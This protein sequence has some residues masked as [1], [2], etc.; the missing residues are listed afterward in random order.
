M[1]DLYQEVTNRIIEQLEAGIIPWNKPWT[2]SNAGA[3]SHNTGRAYSL[4]N[5]ILLMKPGEYLTFNQCKAEGGHIKKG[6]KAQTVVFWKVYPKERKD[7]NGNTVLNENGKPEYDNL[8]VLKYFQVFHIDDCEGITAKYPQPELKVVDPEAEAEKVF[9]G[10]ISREG[11][12]LDRDSISDRAYYSP[13]LDLLH[14]PM[15]HQFDSA[16]EY[17]STAFHEATH[18][19]G[20]TSRLNRFACGAGLAAFGSS[21]Y[22][23]EELVAEIGAACCMARIGIDTA[24]TLKNSAAYIQSWLKALKNDKRMIISAAA[25]AEKAVAMIFGDSKTGATPAPEGGPDSDSK[26]EAKPEAAPEKPEDT[27]PVQAQTAKKAKTGKVSDSYTKSQTAAFKRFMADGKTRPA[28]AGVIEYEGR[29]YILDGYKML[30]L[31]G[32]VSEELKTVKAPDTF[33]KLLKVFSDTGRDASGLVEMPDLK[34]LK[35]SIKLWKAI[36]GSKDRPLVKFEFDGFVYLLD[37][38]YL[39][40]MLQAMPNCRAFTP[41]G[42]NKAMYFTDD[43]DAGIILPVRYCPEKDKPGVHL[44]PEGMRAA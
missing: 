37:A 7:E 11:I 12:T 14:L 2:G 32:K 1:K 43:H 17:Y 10:Y 33:G 42:P 21:D 24:S 41:A 4:I 8:P 9:T 26:P 23:K 3:I 6:A 35:E 36:H 28:Y 34:R 20:H 40:A 31:A 38:N 44:R 19:T 29:N 13:S 30:S 22:S 27:A 15:F 16:A 5:Q 39:A 25:R 18:S